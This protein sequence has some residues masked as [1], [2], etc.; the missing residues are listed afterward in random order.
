MAVGELQNI[1]T[2]TL[3]TFTRRIK[4]V[5]EIQGA[6]IR[7][8]SACLIKVAMLHDFRERGHPVSGM[9]N[10]SAGIFRCSGSKAGDSVGR[11]L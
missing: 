3:A 11:A 1:F 10:M 9:L 2:S 5:T 4:Q 8:R 6:F 7:I